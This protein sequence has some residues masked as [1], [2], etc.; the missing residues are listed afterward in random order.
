MTRAFY[1]A[2]CNITKS[3][4]IRDCIGVAKLAKS[5]QDIKW[6]VNVFLKA[7]ANIP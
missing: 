6:P 4:S 7:E 1:S 5:V 2:I 3:K